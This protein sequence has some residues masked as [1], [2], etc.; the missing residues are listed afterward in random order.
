MSQIQFSIAIIDNGDS[1]RVFWPCEIAPSNRVE[2][3]G[4]QQDTSW[5]KRSTERESV[6]ECSL[7]YTFPR[8]THSLTCVLFFG[9]QNGSEN[10]KEMSAKIFLQPNN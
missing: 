7:S 4:K 5:H 3:D 8:N 1:E 10:A 9:G 6:A 2:V